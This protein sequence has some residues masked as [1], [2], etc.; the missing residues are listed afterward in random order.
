[1]AEASVKAKDDELLQQAVKVAAGHE[2]PKQRSDRSGEYR[3]DRGRRRKSGEGNGSVRRQALDVSAKIGNQGNRAAALRVI[4]EGASETEKGDAASALLEQARGHAVGIGD[5]ALR[6]ATLKD[7]AEAAGQA[8]NAALAASLFAQSLMVAEGIADPY[9]KASALEG[10]A[11]LSG[12]MAGSMAGSLADSVAGSP[13]GDNQTAGLLD[14]ALA[15]AKNIADE[16]NKAT[17]L[18]AIASTTGSAKDG[19]RGE[20]TLFVRFSGSAAKISRIPT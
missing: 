1:M 13:G 8:G 4:A 19:K 6:A 14:Q 3:Q 15:A 20:A 7:L 11:E 2:Q 9:G 10:L 12:S 16:K 5:E 17:S 18:R